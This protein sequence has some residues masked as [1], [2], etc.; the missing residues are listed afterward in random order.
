VDER[1]TIAQL[2]LSFTG[3]FESEL[4]TEL[5]L[6]H[7][8]HPF[9]NDEEFR[10]HLL[11]SAAEIL[12]DSIKGMRLITDVRP[13]DMNLV[14]AVWL[15]EW[16]LLANTAGSAE[17]PVRELWLQTVRRALPSCFCDPD[18]LP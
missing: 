14:A 13:N 2:S 11:E 5:M 10:N 8:N 7:W 6:R 18:L 12:R 17:R 3:A 16:T 9:A 15:A 4:L 1:L